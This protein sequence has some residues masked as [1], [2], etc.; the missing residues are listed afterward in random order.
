MAKQQGGLI[1]ALDGLAP[2]GGE[3]HIWFIRQL[4]R[5]VTLRSA[6]LC[7]QAQPTFEA[8]LEPLKPLAWPMLAGLSD[9]QK[10]L[11][12]AGAAVLPNSRH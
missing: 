12:P 2:Q 1:V 8:F 10:G 5:G 11:G 4:A 9:K 3:P 6:W 7:Q